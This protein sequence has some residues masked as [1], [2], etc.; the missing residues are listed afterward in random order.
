MDAGAGAMDT[1]LTLSALK[2]LVQGLRSSPGRKSVLY[3]TAGMYL[4]PELDTAFHNV[5]SFANSGN[6]TF[7][8]VDAR[9]VMTR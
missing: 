1:R 5:I 3:F 6:V 7:Y 8:A 4:T 2:S 9:G